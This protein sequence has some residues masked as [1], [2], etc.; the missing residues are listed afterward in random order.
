M[1]TTP[2]AITAAAVK[3]IFEAE[4]APEGFIL[5]YDRLH[6]SLGRKSSVAGIF[7][8]SDAPQDRDE[9]VLEHYAEVR[10]YLGWPQEI[11]PATEIDPTPIT[12]Y[13]ERFRRAVEAAEVTASE[14]VWYFSVRG[15]TYPPD[16]TGNITRFHAQIKAFGN[17]SALI[18]TSG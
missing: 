15:I 14:Q 9:L 8:L 6:E 4:F 10:L 13:A 5:K 3:Q 16:P 7:P 12:E 2:F 17:N 1:P 11:N 18:E